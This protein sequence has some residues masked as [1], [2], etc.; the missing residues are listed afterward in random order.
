MS[1]LHRVRRGRES[2]PMATSVAGGRPLSQDV[3]TRGS[4]PGLMTRCWKV[5]DCAD[6]FY[7]DG[8]RAISMT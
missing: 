3:E 1:L 8:A 2:R 7:R 6:K 5:R 4:R